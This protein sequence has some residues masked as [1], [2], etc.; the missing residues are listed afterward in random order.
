MS[1]RKKE[2]KQEYEQ[3]IPKIGVLQIRNTTNDKIFLVAGKDLP[4]LIN[5]HRFQLQKGG[6]PNK[7]L[8]EDWQQSGEHSFA[9]EI[10]EEL[11][12]PEGSFDLKRELEAMEDLWLAE[13]KPFGERGY[14]QPKI[15]RAERLRRIA[16]KRR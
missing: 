9:F 13:L 8:Q 15:T 2:L 6:H 7:A 1:S 11:T 4:A 10:V 16:S 14:N 3:R 5:R 12:L